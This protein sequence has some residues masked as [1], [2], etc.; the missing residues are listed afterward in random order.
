MENQPMRMTE[1]GSN[2]VWGAANIAKEI[3]KDKRGT[4]YLLETGRLPAR[5]A[6][7][8]WVGKRDEL[9]DPTRWPRKTAAV[10]DLLLGEARLSGHCGRA[11]ENRSSWVLDLPGK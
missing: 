3:G 1:D 8:Q 11:S 10:D 6:G 4:Y 7:D 2:L 5:K 9:R